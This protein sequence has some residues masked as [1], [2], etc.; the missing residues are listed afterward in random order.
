MPPKEQR[1]KHLVQRASRPVQ[2]TQQYIDE[3][4][5]EYVEEEASP[6]RSGHYAGI[7]PEDRPITTTPQRPSPSAIPLSQREPTTTKSR[8]PSLQEYDDV[9]QRQPT[10][11]RRYVT[12]DQRLTTVQ[13]RQI[14]HYQEPI[15]PRRRVTQNYQEPIQHQTSAKRRYHPFVFW[16]GLTSVAMIVFLAVAF[17]PSWFAWEHDNIVYG[18]PRTAQYDENVGFGGSSHFTVVNDNG[19]IE[20]TVFTKATKG[21]TV[22]GYS[23]VTLDGANAKWYPATLIFSQGNGKMNILI[24]VN[25]TEYPYMN[26]GKDFAPLKS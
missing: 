4:E 21:S 14:T 17:L 9:T 2:Q 10:S 23:I 20:L 11:A 18:T 26:T 1:V 25:G 7:H 15:M 13:P 5:A 16:S 8:I 24:V 12:T 6:S 22:Q 3:V 19:K